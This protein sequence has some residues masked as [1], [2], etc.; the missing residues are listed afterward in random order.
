M[1]IPP[2]PSSLK[3]NIKILKRGKLYVSG[4]SSFSKLLPPDQEG[5]VVKPHSDILETSQK[6]PISRRNT[7]ISHPSS[8]QLTSRKSL[9]VQQAVTPTQKN[10]AK[11][12][13]IQRLLNIYQKTAQEKL[14]FG[15]LLRNAKSKEEISKITKKKPPPTSDNKF[16]FREI[17]RPLTEQNKPKSSNSLA[18]PLN[19][20]N[21]PFSSLFDQISSEGFQTLKTLGHGS[22]AIVK[23]VNDLR[24]GEVFALKTYEK[25]KLGDPHKMN[26]VRREIIILRKMKHENIVKLQYAFEDCR[27]IHLVMEFVGEMSLQSYMKTKQNKKLD[28]NEARRLFRQVVEGI[29]YCHSKNI[30][31][32]D[33]KLENILLDKEH[34]VKIIDFGFSIIIPA[35]KKLNIFCGTPSYMAPEIITRNYSGQST[36]VWALGILLFVMICGK[37]PF[38]ATNDSELFGKISKGKFSFPENISLGAQEFIRNILKNKPSERLNPSEVFFHFFIFSFWSFINFILDVEK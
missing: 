36:D 25:Y 24:T 11:K 37:F 9:R 2:P 8:A 18:S 28:E 19:L 22:F 21:V 5:T 34:N 13:P 1:S 26:N 6:A 33:I 15:N 4:H 32:R 16:S 17:I 23:L 30:V 7:I 10:E 31:H 3:L 20:W 12:D 14:K 27:K 35:H 38:K 29:N